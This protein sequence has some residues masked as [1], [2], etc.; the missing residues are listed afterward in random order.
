MRSAADQKRC[1]VRAGSR[2]PPRGA[3]R[4]HRRNMDNST[5]SLLVADCLVGACSSSTTASPTL[6]GYQ[7]TS[8]DGS[9]LARLSSTGQP[10]SPSDF[11]DI[12]AFLK[13]QTQ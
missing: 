9:P 3:L 6:S 4:A 10:L 2:A 8:A 1:K 11:A 12:Y 7:I 13:T 5:F